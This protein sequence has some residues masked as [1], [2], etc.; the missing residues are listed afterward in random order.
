MFYTY[1]TCSEGKY[2]F[3]V[4]SE[5]L[6]KKLP[7]G[8]CYFEVF[9]GKKE[10]KCRE[11][12]LKKLS[13]KKL[14]TLI[15][16]KKAGGFTCH[17]DGEKAVITLRN[18]IY[19]L[20]SAILVKGED[21]TI[22]GDKSTI[23][24]G[25]VKLDGWVDEG[26]GVFSASTKYDAD[27]LYINGERYQMAR[28]P[29]YNPNIRIFGGFSRDVLSKGKAD[30]WKNPK[31]AYIH[32]MHL[33]NW[34]GFSYEVT[35][36]DENGNLTY[37]GGWQNN[38]QMGMHSDFKYIENVREEMTEPGEWY[39]DKENGRVYVILKAGHSL[40]SAEICVNSSFFVFKGC[41]NVCLENIKFRRA[42]RTF[43]L[44]SE[45]LLRSDWTIY[46]GGAIYF[47]NSKSSS[48]SKCSLFD[49]GT[50][51]VFVDGKNK[52]ITVSKCHFKDIGASAVCFVG[53]SS[54]VRS[55]LFEAT[56]S[57][58]FLEIDKKRGPKSDEYPKDSSV[59]DCL[60]EH[61][62][63]VEKQATGVEISMSYGI[64]VINTSIYDASR[65]GIN[66]S[67]GTFG[68]HLIDGCDVFD[69]VKETGDHGSFNSWGRDRFWHLSDLAENEIYKYAKLDSLEKTIIRNSRF[70]CD[71]GWDIDLDDGSSNYEIYNN[72]CLNGGIKLRE[73]FNRHIHHNITVNNSIHMHVWYE[74][75]G[76]V[77]E[78]NII[79][80]EYQP[81]LMEHDFGKRI[82]FNVLHS[83]N[84]K[85]VKKATELEKITGMDKGSTKT[86]CVFKDVRHGDYTLLS[87]K[88]S[89]F[90]DFPSEFGVRYEPL[91]KLARTPILPKTNQSQ[92]KG[93]S[94]IIKLFGMKVK[95]IETD[96]EMTVFATAGHN[97]VLVLDVEQFAGALEKG[98]LPYDVIVGVGDK[99]IN[100]L[101]DLEE[102]SK[103]EFLSSK[104]TIWRAPLRIALD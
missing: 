103:G 59:E 62:G 75:C 63:I 77:V 29:K 80:T 76:D 55:P 56:K 15:N 33:H 28:F 2:S 42:K 43:M 97:G 26:G 19:N 102:I 96:G 7:I 100:S 65:A 93:K 53:K 82:D 46:R 25:C 31:G 4:C 73:G 72:L 18:G 71:R 39:Y 49:I 12:Y 69:T 84:T 32:A 54:S 22:K 52:S 67:E 95:N 68:G 89:G 5:L 87:P 51:G 50:N 85:G 35:G 14:S 94:N 78:N 58:S 64:S 23:I 86:K 37:I 6:Y 36:K 60:I 57:Q 30:S 10:A 41:K 45:P 1:L 11:E 91:K 79:F 61:V 88:I 8:L 104:L 38:R 9:E 99:E 92:K 13:Y 20:T 48:I 98:I 17:K 70:R 16:G 66:I 24:Q 44:T 74:N 21:I 47:T 90:E 27:A 3:G 101:A 34:G 83:K 40:D 81:I